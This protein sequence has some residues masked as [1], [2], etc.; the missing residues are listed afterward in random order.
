M[1][2]LVFPFSYIFFLLSVGL[3]GCNGSMERGNDLRPYVYEKHPCL[4]WPF[5]HRLYAPG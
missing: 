5:R 4:S 1:F 3:S 2:C